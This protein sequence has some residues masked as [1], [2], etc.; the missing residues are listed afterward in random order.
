MFTAFLCD[1]HIDYIIVG[2]GIAGTFLS[3]NM[4]KAGKKILVIDKYNPFSASRVASGI[5]NP[6]TGRRI[7]TTWMIDELMSFAQGAYADIGDLLGCV[8]ASETEIINFHATEQMRSAWSDRVAEGDG[9]I[10]HVKETG[11][12]SQ[13]F[14]APYDIGVTSPCLLVDLNI[15][16]SAW[17]KY[18]KEEGMLHEGVFEMSKAV[19][20][21]KEVFYKGIHAQ[22]LILCNGVDGFSNQYFGKLPYSLNKGEALIADIPGLPVGQIYKQAM[23]IVPVGSYFWIGS[24]FEW[25]YEHPYPTDAFRLNVENILAK[26]LKLPYKILE[27]KSSVRPASLERRPF[28]GIHPQMPSLGI[29]N[30]MGTKGCSLAP[31][32]AYQLS[33]HLIENSPINPEADIKRFKKLLSL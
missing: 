30:G 3:Y 24:S 11:R 5:I 25:E 18:L 20:T 21:D 17:R 4:L 29:L 32:F 28:V 6:V 8:V 12:Y 26:W 33:Q 22:K 31:Y 23:S 9:Y 13:F 7:V 27:H 19:L 15:L 14:H 2:Q 16:L 1:V 10:R